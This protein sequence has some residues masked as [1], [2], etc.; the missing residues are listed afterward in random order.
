MADTKMTYEQVRDQW[1][2]RAVKDT[3]DIGS[4]DPFW[5]SYEKREVTDFLDACGQ[6]PR[7]LDLGAGTGR[8]TTFLHEQGYDVTATDYA[9]EAIKRLRDKHPGLPAHVLD[10]NDLS[11]L[12]GE[13]DSVILCRV[14]QS[15]PDL[16]Q[17][18]KALSKIRSK[19]SIDGK[20][21]L[22]EGNARRLTKHPKYNFYL[23]LDD[24]KD[25]FNDEGFVLER[26]SSIPTA[27]L[28]GLLDG[29]KLSWGV[30]NV[31]PAVYRAAYALDRVVGRIN[32]GVI[33]HEFAMTVR[34][35]YGGRK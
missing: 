12:E 27:T 32:P 31:V 18:K 10:I 7:V 9:E 4:K 5:D 19:L 15:M 23:S 21:L 2:E 17:K 16:D 28:L 33:S 1:N 3:I 35:E 34:P 20:V 29:K 6:N 13:F 24:W 30:R 14:L 22:I 26:A 8:L 25:T 11:E